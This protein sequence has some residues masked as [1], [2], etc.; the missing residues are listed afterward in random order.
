MNDE[1]KYII[2][3]TDQQ[4]TIQIPYGKING[5]PVCNITKIYG[6]SK[7]YP[8]VTVLFQYD[9]INYCENILYI[10]KIIKYKRLLF[11]LL[12]LE[13]IKTILVY[14]SFLI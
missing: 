14:S 7:T 12:P 3:K 1:S 5:I 11:S 13:L 4:I 10:F 2:T 8:R 6:S 9:L